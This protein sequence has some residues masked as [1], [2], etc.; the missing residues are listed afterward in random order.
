MV[1]CKELINFLNKY[2]LKNPLMFIDDKNIEYTYHLKI[3][4]NQKKI[5]IIFLIN[6]KNKSINITHFLEENGNILIEMESFFSQILNDF[7][8]F[9]II[10][11]RFL[12]N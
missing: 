11:E 9:K 2:N 7:E 12:K 4:I 10:L 3:Y 5:R 8:K 1:R 6:M